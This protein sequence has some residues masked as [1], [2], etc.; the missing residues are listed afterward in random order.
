MVH[1]LDGSAA[2]WFRTTDLGNRPKQARFN[3][4]I[5]YKVHFPVPST[6]LSMIA[7]NAN[8]NCELL[9]SPQKQNN[10]TECFFNKQNNWT[11]N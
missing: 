5:S 11:V 3:S 9:K 7:R 2:R 4:E 1:G 6:V 8:E 10:L